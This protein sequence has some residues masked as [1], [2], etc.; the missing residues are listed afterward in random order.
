MALKDSGEDR[1]EQLCTEIRS[2]G[3]VDQGEQ[4]NLI[5]RRRAIRRSYVFGHSTSGERRQGA[6]PVDE[7]RRPTYANIATFKYP[8]ARSSTSTSEGALGA[9]RGLRGFVAE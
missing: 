5:M 4:D 1:H 6:E 3:N 7:R 2:D 8:G 9:I